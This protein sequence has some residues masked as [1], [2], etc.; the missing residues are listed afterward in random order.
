[1][2]T[3]QASELSQLDVSLAT[4]SDADRYLAYATLYDLLSESFAY[5]GAEFYAKLHSGSFTAK[6]S[7]ATVALADTPALRGAQTALQA[8]VESTLA[9]CALSQLES[10]YIALFD[11]SRDQPAVHP[12]ARLYG[13]QSLNPAVLLQKLQAIYREQGLAL[14]AD[15]GAEQADHITVQL[16][17]MALLFQ[18]LAQAPDDAAALDAVNAFLSQLAWLPRFVVMLD[19]R[20][21]SHW[22]YHPLAHFLAVIYA[23][24]PGCERVVL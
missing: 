7:A 4:A 13:E 23:S 12:Y 1:M 24:D 20:G 2:E 15:R 10:D 6:V 22:F 14:D 19:E 5:P 11:A 21:F 8:A 3:G 9:D 18:R 16:E 17:F